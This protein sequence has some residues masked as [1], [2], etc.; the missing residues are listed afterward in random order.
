MTFVARLTL[1]AVVLVGAAPHA[2][3]AASLTRTRRGPSSAATCLA[4]GRLTGK[5]MRIVNRARHLP[6]HTKFVLVL[7]ALG[8]VVFF[9]GT[10]AKSRL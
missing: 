6:R 7:C 3:D 9:V 5:A 10:W 4:A 1:A 8:I 2:S